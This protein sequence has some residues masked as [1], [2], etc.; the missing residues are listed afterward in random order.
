M[1]TSVQG[2]PRIGKHRELK[3]A[4]EAWLRG[5]LSEGELHATGKRIR[6]ESW[7]KMAEAGIDRIPSNDFS[8]Y[9]PLLDT[10]CL[11]GAI[12]EPYRIMGLSALE[13]LFAMARGRQKGETDNVKAL[14]MR[15]WFNTNYHYIVSELSDGTRFSLSHPAKPVEEFLEALSL[16]ISTT[17]VI[18]GAMTF[19]SLARLTGNRSRSDYADDLARVY[20]ELLSELAEA[21]AREVV[22]DEPYLASDLD[23]SDKSLFVRLYELI[24]PAPLDVALQIPYGDIRDVWQE[25]MSLPFA[26]IALDFIE[27]P[28]NL[29]LLR[30]H[31]FPRKTILT[32][33]IISGKNVWKTDE[34]QALDLLG[35]ISRLS[36]C[37]SGNGRLEAGIASS[38]VHVPLTVAGESAL[39]PAIVS[40]LSFAEE[41]LAELVLLSVCCEKTDLRS[42]NPN[43]SDGG[44]G[45]AS[46][47]TAPTI[48]QEECTRTPERH[49]RRTIQARRFA[50]PPLP[51]TTIGSFPQTS[52]V[53]SLRAAWRKGAIDTTTYTSRIRELTVDCIREQ[54]ELGLDVLVHGEFERTDMVEFF[55]QQLKGF[56]F[57]ANG[58]VQ[59]YGTRC[60]KPPLIVS[61]V[62]RKGP[63]TVELSVYAQG[64]TNKPVKGMLTGPVT[65]LNWSFPREDIPLAA[66]AFQIAR[67]LREEVL[68]LERNGIGII[69]IDE[70]ALQE[71]L[72]RRKADRRAAYLSWAIP[73]FRMTHAGVK[74]ETQI[75]T[76]MCYSDFTGIVRDIDEMDADVITFEAARSDHAL[77][78]FLAAEHFQTAVGPGIYDIHS[79]RV[80]DVGELYDAI[81]RCAR[82][83]GKHGPAFDGLWVNPDCGLKTRGREET[84]HSLAN[85]VEATRLVRQEAVHDID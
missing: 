28:E 15:K 23:E 40:R 35:E 25:V 60:V 57:T 68:D 48:P 12:P 4:T 65:I 14:P 13:T 59:S 39:D 20:R 17:P 62:S 10:A 61:D 43:D 73:A 55:G 5:E 72:P 34:G 75:H 42:F 1:K 3:F 11:V 8:L 76:H 33:G 78:A 44:E 19:L 49:I 46:L 51:T 22:F 9:D 58:W 27:G 83:L 7:K 21:G 31:S 54:E 47:Y 53:R 16:G 82:L 67:A 80:P 2:Y 24:T 64:L 32:A 85:L 70:A 63:M 81:H 71:K 45:P 74:P 30:K 26:R 79:P 77:L 18:P 52:E 6:A 41:K 29:N 36:G 50:L 66:Q 38:L 84:I 69:Q 37:T 56:A